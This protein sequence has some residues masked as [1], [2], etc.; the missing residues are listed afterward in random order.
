MTMTTREPERVDLKRRG[1]EYM[2]KQSAGKSLQEQLGYWQRR[3]E[4]L[5]AKQAKAKSQ[6]EQDVA[7][8]QQR[9]AVDGADAR[10]R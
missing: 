7:Q 8:P 1:V 10:R 9:L 6:V 2:A 5:L 3:T 4:A